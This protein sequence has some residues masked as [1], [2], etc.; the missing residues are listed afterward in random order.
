MWRHRASQEESKLPE[1]RRG[2]GGAV[3]CS[4]TEAPALPEARLRSGE[5]QTSHRPG[6]AALQA[7]RTS[8]VIK[9]SVILFVILSAW[10]SILL[11]FRLK[12]TV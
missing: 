7:R 9:V 2:P 12:A 10:Q 11:T 5:V 1:T 6:P 8:I 4:E 3:I